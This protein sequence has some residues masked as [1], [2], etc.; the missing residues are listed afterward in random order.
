MKANCNFIAIFAKCAENAEVPDMINFPFRPSPSLIAAGLT[1]AGML[2]FFSCANVVA[3]TGGPRDEDPPEVVRSTPPDQTTQFRGNQIRI[4]FNEFVR[5]ENIRQQLLVSPP[6][7]QM[8][9]V[10]LRGRS[11]IIDIQ[12]ELRPQTTYNIFFGDAIRDITESNAIP[13]FQ[14]VFSTGDYVDSLMVRGQ[15]KNAFTLEPEEGVFVMMYDN[16]YDSVPYLERPV[17]VAKTDKEGQFAISNM[18]G[19]DYLMFALLDQNANF[20]YDLPGE[21]IAFANELVSPKYIEPLHNGAAGTLSP[22]QPEAPEEGLPDGPAPEPDGEFHTLYLFQEADTVQRV[23]S[24]RLTRKGLLTIA[25]RVPFDSAYVR[26]IRQPFE[27]PWHIPEFSSRNDTLKIWFSDLERDSLFLEVWDAGRRLDTIRQATRPRELRGRDVS[28]ENALPPLELS[29]NYRRTSAVP[30]FE[31]LGI[32]SQHPIR[33]IR[34]EHFQLFV[35]DTLPAEAVFDFRDHVRREILMDPLPEQGSRYR[36]EV[37]PGALTDIFGATNDT[38]IAQFTTT[39]PENYGSLIL[40][41]GLPR[42]NSPYILQLL[43]RNMDLLREKVIREDGTYRFAKLLAGNYNIRL[44]EDRNANGR[45]DPGNYL[46]GIQ[47]EAVFI[48]PSP[49]QVRENWDVEMPWTLEPRTE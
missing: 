31:P 8:P 17:Y 12:E 46:K 27:E 11:V 45:W 10:R 28:G 48:F 22:P 4:F 41:V 24:S 42:H 35:H 36:L 30:Y 23:T 47:P 7:E 20:L 21:K 37:M 13:N 15:V 32:I 9:E 29:M 16:P 33:E 40:P 2:L 39:E 3:P 1:L 34:Q 44:I 18:G 25:F 19:G 26:E 5:L 43:D 6:M 38:L 14:F 49:I